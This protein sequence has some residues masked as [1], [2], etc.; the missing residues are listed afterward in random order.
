MSDEGIKLKEPTNELKR[1]LPLRSLVFYGIAMIIPMT[2][3][4]TYG[5]ATTRTHGMVSF[6]YTIATIGMAF[7]AFSYSKMVK[8]YP[9]AGSAYTYVS[10]SMNPYIGF[11]AGW[12][13][14]LAYMVLPMLN[15]VVMGIYFSNLIPQIPASV[16]IIAAILVVTWVNYRGIKLATIVDTILVLL[17]LAFLA[18]FFVMVIRYILRGGGAGTL[19]D[20]RAYF[21]PVEFFKPGVGMPAILSGASMLALSF[22][23]FDAIATLSEEAIN[24][25]KNVGRAIIIA[26]VGAG[27][28]FIIA[29]YFLQLAWPNAF[30]EIVDINSA[31][32]EL[33]FRITHSMGMKIFFT[34][35]FGAGLFISSLTGVASGAR[36]LYGMGKNGIL[37]YKIFGKVHLKYKTPMYSILIMG[38]L[39]LIAIVISLENVTATVNFGSLLAFV[40]VNLSVIA[41]YFIRNSKRRG[42]DIIKYLIAPLCGAFICFFIWAKVD[43]PSKVVG[44]SW[45]ILGLV[46]L[47]IKTKF[48]RKLP[49]EIMK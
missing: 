48:F 39:G 49:P 9:M 26:C 27:G 30:F 35:T 23:G 47:A 16:F 7:T 44:F 12:V 36:I 34:A 8:K 4:T 15:Y 43:M 14:L 45:I 22:L 19:V 1:I 21:N 18:V 31:A 13:L 17:Q 11:L 6:T 38:L 40:F 42:M 41:Q 3:F 25:E 10:K 32:V 28:G 5:I 2:I 46:Y 29:M 24:P 20:S 33:I 37:P